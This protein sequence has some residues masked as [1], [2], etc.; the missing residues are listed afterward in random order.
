MFKKYLCDYAGGGTPPPRSPRGTPAS[1]RSKGKRS[2]S[3]PPG[4][5][6]GGPA[7]RTRASSLGTP[8]TSSSKPSSTPPPHPSLKEEKGVPSRP[9]R[10]SSDIL[11][12]RQSLEQDEEEASSLAL[13]LMRG[14]VTPK[15]RRPWPPCLGRALR[16]GLLCI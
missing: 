16:R 14:V 12:S 9:S 8:P 6:P 7:K 15:D 10:A 13:T 5:T 1:N 4:V 3:P 2:V 11:Y